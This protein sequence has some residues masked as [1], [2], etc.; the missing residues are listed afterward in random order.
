M[1]RSNR[2]DRIKDKRAEHGLV[3][4]FCIGSKQSKPLVTRK[5]LHQVI[6]YDHD[7]QS[8]TS[9]EAAER[10]MQ[11]RYDQKMAKYGRVR[12]GAKQFEV[13]ADSYI[14]KIM[15]RSVLIFHQFS[16][17][18]RRFDGCTCAC[19]CDLVVLYMQKQIEKVHI[20]NN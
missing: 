12:C 14:F 20:T 13:Y 5:L 4:V 15:S 6:R 2:I 8:K 10:P 18:M 9:D 1:N 7:G 3:F 19:G 16:Y 11:V 17:C